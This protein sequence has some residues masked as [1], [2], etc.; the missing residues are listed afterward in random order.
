MKNNKIRNGKELDMV[1]ILDQSG[2]MTGSEKSTITSYNEYLEKE[3]NNKEFIFTRITTVLFNDST[4]FINSRVPIQAVKNMT[5]EDYRPSGCTALYD[6]IGEAI[7]FME[8]DHSGK[9]MFVIVTDGYENASKEYNKDII[10]KLI[11]KHKNWEFIFIG[12]DID[13]YAV[14]AQMGI[15]EDRIANYKKDSKGTSMLF[16]SV[17]RVQKCYSVGE[18]T[19]SEWK[20]ELEKYIEESR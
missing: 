18:K 6:S 14:G 8:K 15:S 7:T 2:S 13:S 17:Q 12:A 19:T 9:V 10:K 11:K 5:K 1:F 20:E 16:D 3:R 4:N